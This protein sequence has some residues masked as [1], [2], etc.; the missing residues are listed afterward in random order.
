MSSTAPP[1]PASRPR[2]PG[3][4]RSGFW[5]IALSFLLTMAFATVPAPLYALYQR[6]DHFPTFTLTLV[7]GAYAVGVATALV[8]IGHLSDV[9]GRKRSVLLA[10]A[11]ALVSAVVFTLRTDVAWLLAARFTSG[12]AVGTL[13]SAATAFLTELELGAATAKV[14][15][16]RA[17]VIAGVVNL[18][19]LGLGALVSGGLADLVRRPLLIPYLVFAILFVVALVAVAL[20]PETV[21]VTSPA[22]PYRPQRVRAP[23]GGAAEFRAAA[24]AAFAV[25]AVLGLFTSVAPT[26]LA[27]TFG[28]TDRFL[29]GGAT[30]V[31]FGGAALAQVVFAGRSLASHGRWGVAGIATGLVLLGVAALVVEAWLF[32]A[33]SALTGIGVGLLFRAAIGTA[34]SLARPHERGGILATTFLIGY[35]GMV[36]P[37]V[38]TGAL[39]LVLPATTV[40]IGFVVVVVAL[41]SWA[42]RRLVLSLDAG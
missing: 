35:T 17:N 15:A 37:V 33:A 29:A 20:V 7:F 42:G 28:V 6:A 24:T 10:L 25:F 22:P 16:A 13:T 11:L 5:I 19:G 31:V 21:E 40:L 34:A 41:A 36:V 12:L 2:S 9:H 8:L 27:L 14:G 32:V 1:R 26:F 39:L 3:Q 23:E 30:F 4:H 38:V 18:G